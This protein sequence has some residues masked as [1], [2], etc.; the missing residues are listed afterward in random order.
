MIRLV[1]VTL[2][3]LLAANV[4]AQTNPAAAY[5][6]KP[7]RVVVAVAPGG[8][9]DTAARILSEHV[10]QKLG[11][12][13]VMD[14]RGGAA[15]NVGAGLV[16]QSDPDGYTILASSLSPITITGLLRK[17][18]KFDPAAFQP[19]VVMSRIP[20]VLVAR[21]SLPVKSVKELLAYINANAGKANYASPGVGTA[22]YLS[23]ELFMQ[24]TGTKLIHVPYKG[25]AP[26]LVDLV[27]G[28][29]DLTF[30]Q[31]AAIFPL[32]KGKR[33]KL[34]ATATTERLEFIPEIPTLAEVGVRG[35]ESYTWNAIS[36]PPKTPAP[37]IAKLNAAY[38]GALNAPE[39][40]ARYRALY[41]SSGIGNLAEVRKFVK[42]ETVRW[43]NV[44]R[45]AGLKPE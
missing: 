1:T 7:V 33:V 27:G 18:L 26:S 13:F 34:L 36:A 42:D 44:I 28:H 35:A 41:M 22:A 23:A 12:P 9:I 20:N 17:N 6:N 40:K 37:I 2:A 30:A 11:Q 29:V 32:Y 31:I 25:T 24:I 8:G 14:N 38:N 39:V 16:F 21:Q 4:V 10:R 45:K 3:S 5:P 19:I 43:G 15:G